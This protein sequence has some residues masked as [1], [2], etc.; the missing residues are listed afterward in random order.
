MRYEYKI[1]Q[2]KEKGFAKGEVKWLELESR[3]NVLGAEGWNIQ[4]IQPLAIG[5]SQSGVVVF[6]KREV[7]A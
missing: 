5:S 4:D 2:F 7:A 3:L 1:E 6:L